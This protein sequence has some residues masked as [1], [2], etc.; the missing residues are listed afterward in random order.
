MNADMMLRSEFTVYANAPAE[1]APS[2]ESDIDVQRD[3]TVIH[4]PPFRV[5]IHNDDVTTFD[6]VINMLVTIFKLARGHAERVATITHVAGLA[7][8]CVRP[9][10]EAERL[11]NQGMFAARLEG[12]PLR[13]SCEPEAN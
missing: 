9:Q 12:F 13:L 1:G 5:L 10:S 6:F 4:E 3:T 8:V 7:L 11:V 2:H